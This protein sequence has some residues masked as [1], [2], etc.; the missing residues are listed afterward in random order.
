M[1][2]FSLLYFLNYYCARVNHHQC[3]I[4]VGC[5]HWCPWRF[6]CQ[7]SAHGLHFFSPGLQSVKTYDTIDFKQPSFKYQLD[8]SKKCLKSRPGL[9]NQPHYR[10]W[11]AVQTQCWTAQ[12]HWELQP[13]QLSGKTR[14]K[15]TAFINDRNLAL[16][17]LQSS[18]LHHKI[19]RTLTVATFL[20]SLNKNS[21]PW[22]WVGSMDWLTSMNHTFIREKINKN[23]FKVS[24]G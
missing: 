2:G 20:Q 11:S 10:C 8:L 19:V 12:I 1:E 7:I 3:L 4:G 6:S 24:W 17:L 16:E 22:G 5:H 9:R 14:E 13:H 15:T 23:N 21:R 18:L